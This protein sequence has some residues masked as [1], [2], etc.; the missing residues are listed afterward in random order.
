MDHCRREHSF[1]G[2]CNL[3]YDCEVER[4][5]PVPKPTPEFGILTAIFLIIFLLVCTTL[6]LLA[7]KRA[8]SLDGYMVGNRDIGP[9]V[10]GLALGAAWISGWAELGG[11]GIAYTVGWSGMWF[12]GIWT[13]V[14]IVPCVFLAARKVNEFSRANGARTLGEI[15]GQRYDCRVT[16]TVAVSVMAVLCFMYTIGQL[17]AAGTAWYA[18]TGFSPLTCL[19]LSIAVVLIYMLIGGYAGTQWSMAFQAVILSAGLFVLA[20]FALAYVGG[21]GGL[22]A[23]LSAQDPKLML[24]MRPD[25]PRV[26]PTQLFSS[27]TGISATMLLFVIMGSG[28]AHTTSRFLGMTRL[29]KKGFVQMILCLWLVTGPAILLNSIVG[30]VARATYGPQLLKIL[31]WKADLAAPFIAMTVG[32]PPVAALY[33]AG[34][35]AAALSTFS[36]L[37]LVIATG[38]TND[39]VRTWKPDVTDR[40]LLWATRAVIAVVAIFSFTWTLTNPPALLAVFVG[41]AGAGLGGTFIFVVTISLWWK[42]ATRVGAIL[43]SVYGLAATLGGSYLVAKNMIGMG[44]VI[45]GI[46]LGCGILFVAGSLLSAPMQKEKLARIFPDERAAV[47]N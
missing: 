21:G 23:Q 16:R 42:R 45:W 6:G 34:V 20:M 47:G 46:F 15:I 4:M 14:G 8:T 10:T 12:A 22:N 25:L 18:V 17:K 37:L 35:F 9:A 13:L 19:L 24:L 29:T 43:C 31:P 32:G 5:I 40:T 39:I 36:A 26:G 27:I 7:R 1:N 2:Y 38:I 3:D 33:S 11:M 28:F 41:Q 44:T 30:L